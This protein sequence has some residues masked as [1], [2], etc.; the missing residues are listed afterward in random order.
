MVQFLRLLGARHASA[1]EVSQFMLGR[2][3]NLSVESMQISTKLC[4]GELQLKVGNDP[5]Y[6]ACTEHVLSGLLR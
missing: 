3:P 1:L 2:T 4:D 5:Y 6:V